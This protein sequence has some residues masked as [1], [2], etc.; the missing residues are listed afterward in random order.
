MYDRCAKVK[1]MLQGAESKPSLGESPSASKG[2]AWH[3]VHIQT[4]PSFY[5]S[6][7]L[8]KA[9]KMLL[10]IMRNSH[11]VKVSQ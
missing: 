3:E 5:T 4:E 7:P 9:M 10:L 1:P 6:N 2:P 11:V 8:G